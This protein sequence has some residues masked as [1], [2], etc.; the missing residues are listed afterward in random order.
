MRRA[1]SIQTDIETDLAWCGLN[2]RPPSVRPTAR[3]RPTSRRVRPTDLMRGARPTDLAIRPVPGLN[4]RP[5]L[6][7]ADRRPV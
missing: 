2:F 3:D 5:D 7:G 1:R 4:Y 6:T